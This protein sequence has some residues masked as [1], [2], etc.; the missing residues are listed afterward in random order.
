MGLKYQIVTILVFLFL[1][2]SCGIFISNPRISNV[3][4]IDCSMTETTFKYSDSTSNYIN[5]NIT[6]NTSVIVI[7]IHGLGAH[8]GSFSS[9]QHFFYEKN[10]SS[11]S[12]DLRGFGHWSG[13][14]GDIDNIG[15]HLDDLKQ[16]IYCVKSE[17]KPNKIILLGESLGSSLAI[18]Y[19]YKNPHEVDGLILTS[20]VTT[21]RKSQIS[22]K[23]ALKLLIGYTFIP[24]KPISLD[25]EPKHFSNNEDFIEWAFRIDTLG[26]RK[27]STR[28]LV[29]SNRVIKNSYKQLCSISIPTLILQGGK[30]LLSDKKDIE[31]ILSKCNNSRI[32]HEYYADNFHFLINDTNRLVIFDKIN[33]WLS[34]YILK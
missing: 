31:N 27:I 20:L 25:Y 14:K 5:K 22:I 1:T 11:V 13:K 12:I 9:I 8:A 34:E 3:K 32:S 19:A 16:V 23:S 21:H 4:S 10:I 17:Y 7:C 33:T 26:T 29:Q 2:S 15:V 28:Y 30:D 6:S 18:W 24:R